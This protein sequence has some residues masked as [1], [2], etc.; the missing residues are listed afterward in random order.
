MELFLSVTSTPALLSWKSVPL[1][2]LFTISIFTAFNFILYM[3]RVKKE[4]VTKKEYLNFF[5][6][7]VLRIT[8]SFLI[9]WLIHMIIIF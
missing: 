6:R 9:V 1:V 8:I 2:Y 4:Q 3:D 7:N 5:K